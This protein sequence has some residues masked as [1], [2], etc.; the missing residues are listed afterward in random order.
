[1]KVYVLGATGMLGSYV[2]K[3]LR[4]TDKY[5][6]LGLSRKDM[7]ASKWDAF[8]LMNTFFEAEDIIIN[9]IGLI[10]Q[11][12]EPTKLDF[13]KVNAVFP[14]ELANAC[15]SMHCKLIH[16]TTDCVF[17]GVAGNY[18]EQSP[19]NATD[20]YGV[21]KSLGEPEN[22][23]VIRTSIIGEEK[24]NKLS[25][26][27]WIKKQAGK[28]A[29]GY[30]NHFWNGITCLQYAK[31]CEKIIDENLFWRGVKHIVSPTAVSKMEL[32]EMVSGIY[33][34]KIKVNPFKAPTRCDRTMTST[35]EDVK[36]EVPEIEQQIMEMK[37]FY[38]GTR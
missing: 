33:D 14:L 3:Y 24:N 19:H 1:M 2:Y 27:E 5:N 9:C 15:E 16:I 6:T 18:D 23:T 36:I 30:T 22:A 21:S 37:E 7:D 26:V 28:Q 35:R 10:T 13:I 25:L 11:R 38:D 29:N 31:I 4:D 32:M 34:L 20:I 17:D 8:D 12:T